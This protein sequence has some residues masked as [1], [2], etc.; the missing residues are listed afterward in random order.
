MTNQEQPNVIIF[1]LQGSVDVSV[2]NA[3]WLLGRLSGVDTSRATVG[4]KLPSIREVDDDDGGDCEQVLGRT[5]K[6]HL[7]SYL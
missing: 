4:G 6:I 1:P 7:I 2:W 3:Q 5:I